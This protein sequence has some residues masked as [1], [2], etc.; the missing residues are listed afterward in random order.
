MARLMDDSALNL[1][2]LASP[3]AHKGAAPDACPIDADATLA[4]RRQ[5]VSQ[6]QVDQARA[7]LSPEESQQC[8]DETVN[9]FLRATVGNTDQARGLQAG[10][11]RLRHACK[12]V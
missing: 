8:S 11:L 4:A 6:E 1:P 5:Q 3:P 2:A 7:R 12:G 9:Q 10:R